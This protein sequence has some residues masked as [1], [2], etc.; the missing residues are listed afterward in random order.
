MLNWLNIFL[1]TI[2]S[3][4]NYCTGIKQYELGDVYKAGIT[5]GQINDVIKSAGRM[6]FQREWHFLQLGRYK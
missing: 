3:K 5:I 6:Q 4:V 2:E 1:N